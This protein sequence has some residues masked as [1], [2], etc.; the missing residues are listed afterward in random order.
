MSQADIIGTRR[1]KAIIHP[2]VTEVALL[3]NP[4]VLIEGNGRMGTDF[5]T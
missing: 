5:N 2:V 3:C 1:E 4:F